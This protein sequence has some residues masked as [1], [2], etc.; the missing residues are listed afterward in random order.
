MNDL[1]TVLAEVEYILRTYPETRDSD[2]KL[3]ATYLAR[4][5]VTTVSVAEF[6]NNFKKYNVS[7]F[8]SVTRLRRKVVT[9][10]P[11]LAP[12][13]RIQELREGRQEAFIEI[14]RE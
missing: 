7:D 5:K 2:E 3:Y 11:E 1:K 10:N 12:A 6:L 4:H 8:E 13:Q 9:K 14:S